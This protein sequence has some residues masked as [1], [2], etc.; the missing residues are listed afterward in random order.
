MN[1]TGFIAV[2]YL[3][4]LGTYPVPEARIA[5]VPIPAI[6]LG[7]IIL[8]LLLNHLSGYRV[9]LTDRD[10]QI[11][12]MSVFL[13]SWL[14]LVTAASSAGFGYDVDN[15]RYIGIG[16]ILTFPF[17]YLAFRY[18]KPAWL[19]W[20][21]LSA[22]VIALSVGYY[23]FFSASSGISSEHALGYWGIK[24]QPATRNSD[25]LY[26][27]AS[28]LIATTLYSISRHAVTRGVLI[29]IIL[30]A[31]SAVILSLSR[32]AWLALFTGFAG[33]LWFNR[34][35]SAGVRKRLAS[36]A[37]I[38]IAS[39]IAGAMYLSVESI[40]HYQ[41]LSDR[42]FSIVDS[43]DPRVSN[44]DR[45]D[46]ARDAAIG[47]WRHPAGVGVGNSSFALGRPVHSD[48][49]AE[50][51]WL[52]M[53][54]EGGWPAIITFTLLLVSLVLPNAPAPVDPREEYKHD[55]TRSFG[56]TI[57]L[58]IC[59]YLMFNYELNSLFLWSLLAA[60]WATKRSGTRGAHPHHIGTNRCLQCRENTGGGASIDSLTDTTGR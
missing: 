49:H 43:N 21:L 14:T 27:V 53:G 13:A 20:A 52:A 8:I 24:Y 4:S 33:S 6:L 15:H 1:V 44:R 19:L 2:L 42:V 41:A 47:L 16:Y 5:T 31:F 59:S 18:L 40:S 9:S 11:F 10:K 56:P 23:R 48:A 38:I 30:M 60:A 46:L 39:V 34:N 51:A 32:S 17:L 29:F 37:G 22:G 45:V 57:I 7:A 28:A 25:A 54:L 3:V 55:F 36:V 26:P 50:N 35:H 58:A 12:S